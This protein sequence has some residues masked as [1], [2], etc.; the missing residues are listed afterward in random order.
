MR[1]AESA[2][3]GINKEKGTMD[4]SYRLAG[5]AA[6]AFGLAFLALPL[7]VT[8]L[9]PA[10]LGTGEL[11]IGSPSTDPEIVLGA[12][13]LGPIEAGIFLVM[14]V[15]MA[16]L[17]L[18]LDAIADASRSVIA[19]AHF[20]TGIAAALGWLVVAAASAATYS[21][22][23]ETATPFGDE[24]RAVF[25]LSHA[26]DIITGVFLASIASG[27]WW[28]G[29]AANAT[30]ARAIGRGLALLAA[31]GGFLVLAPSLIGFPWGVVLLIPLSIVL[32]VR[33]LVRSGRQAARRPTVQAAG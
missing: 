22:V 28:I 7:V 20:L 21:T 2:V 29:C 33:L 17:A 4:R 27:M 24:G 23:I 6:L 9:V 5:L 26:M 8:L 16:V 1:G 18:G 19:R 31:I 32:G 12:R 30:A 10:V 14:A 3:I 25:F 11:E 13:W 15:S